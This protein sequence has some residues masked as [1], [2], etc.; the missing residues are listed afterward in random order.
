MPYMA[1]FGREAVERSSGMIARYSR[2]PASGWIS[3]GRPCRLIVPS[4]W[5]EALMAHQELAKQIA[6]YAERDGIVERS[7]FA[8]RRFLGETIEIIVYF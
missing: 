3:R 4:A 1:L 2:L 8:S 6:R 7:M 5:G